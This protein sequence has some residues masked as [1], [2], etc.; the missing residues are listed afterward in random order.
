[1][2]QRHVRRTS[3][4]NTE[5]GVRARLAG[6][7]IEH[8]KTTELRRMLAATVEAIGSDSVEAD[9]LRRELERRRRKARRARRGGTK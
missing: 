2:G 4:D 9:L 3:A 7:N 1:M 8:V 6:M 5:L